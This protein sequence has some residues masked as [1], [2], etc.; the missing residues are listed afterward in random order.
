MKY[1]LLLSFLVCSLTGLQAQ[2]V[3]Q[4]GEDLVQFSGMVLDGGNSQ[5]FPVPYATVLINND[6]RGTYSL[7]LIPI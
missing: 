4:N 2:L 5:L 1:L 6:G 7:S 3:D